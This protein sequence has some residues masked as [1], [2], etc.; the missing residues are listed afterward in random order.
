MSLWHYGKFAL[1]R[2]ASQLSWYFILV[3]PCSV[4]SC[5]T[6]YV[7]CDILVPPEKQE[8]TSQAAEDLLLL[9]ECFLFPFFSIMV[10]C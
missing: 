8:E 10:Q 9:S 5:L 6:L 4:F 3:L 7:S 1:L 2:A